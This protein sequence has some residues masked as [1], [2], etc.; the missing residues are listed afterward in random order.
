MAY[1]RP[2]CRNERPR[3]PR[4][5]GRGAS[6][7][8]PRLEQGLG[9][10]RLPSIKAVE[11]CARRAR[12]FGIAEAIGTGRDSFAGKGGIGVDRP[13]N[14]A[15][16]LG[17]GQDQRCFAVGVNRE[18][19]SVDLPGILAEQYLLPFRAMDA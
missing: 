3:L 7:P 16:R 14:R 12:Q 13:I 15:K 19:T 9:R 6:L 5:C 2:D 1:A 4:C 10:L 11:D 8:E 18:Q 17:C